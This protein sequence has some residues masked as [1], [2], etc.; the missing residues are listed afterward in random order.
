MML[1]EHNKKF[2]HVKSD[3]DK[4]QTDKFCVLA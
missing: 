4:Y 2:H 3:H 1:N